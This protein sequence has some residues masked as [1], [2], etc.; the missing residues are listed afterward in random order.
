MNSRKTL[1]ID[2][3]LKMRFD[4]IRG[5]SANSKMALLLDVY[6]KKIAE[7]DNVYR[8]INAHMIDLKGQLNS[9]HKDIKSLSERIYQLEQ[10]IRGKI[11]M[12]R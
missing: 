7:E 2:E 6:T 3:D 12:L 11:E 5:S 1:Q 4:K 9:Y 10:N 8:L